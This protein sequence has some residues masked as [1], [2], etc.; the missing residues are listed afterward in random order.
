MYIDNKNQLNFGMRSVSIIGS[1]RFIRNVRAYKP[2]EIG[3]P[4]STCTITQGRFGKVSVQ[5]SSAMSTDCNIDGYSFLRMFF[6]TRK[7]ILELVHKANDS[8]NRKLVKR[9]RGLIPFEE[10]NELPRLPLPGP[11]LKLVP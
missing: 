4:E 1:K 10:Q 9:F 6:V 5:V 7:R 8:M 2:E 3:I 11:H